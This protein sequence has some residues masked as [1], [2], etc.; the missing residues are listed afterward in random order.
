MVEGHGTWVT[1]GK[2]VDASSTW[3]ISVHDKKWEK[4]SQLPYNVLESVSEENDEDS[5][6]ERRISS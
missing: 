3:E 2:R 1:K 6:R 4:E 5:E